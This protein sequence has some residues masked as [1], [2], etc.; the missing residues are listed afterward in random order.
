MAL[1][2]ASVSIPAI[3]IGSAFSAAAN[4]ALNTTLKP[5]FSPYDNNLLFLHGTA[6]Q[7]N[8]QM[9][10]RQLAEGGLTAYARMPQS[11]SQS[12]SACE[13]NQTLSTI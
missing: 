5:S 9:K 1:G 4:A 3:N 13:V 8:V 7:Q 2:N 10:N 11:V 12:V 6:C